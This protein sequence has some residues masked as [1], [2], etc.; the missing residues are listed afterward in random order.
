MIGDS[1]QFNDEENIVSYLANEENSPFQD[2][3]LKYNTIGTLLDH[4][5]TKTALVGEDGNYINSKNTA[6]RLLSKTAQTALFNYSYLDL[7]A[8]QGTHTIKPFV[9]ADIFADDHYVVDIA[10]HVKSPESSELLA[11]ENYSDFSI[12]FEYDVVV[13]D[14]YAKFSPF[15]N[16]FERYD[17][18]ADDIPYFALVGSRTAKVSMPADVQAEHNNNYLSDTLKYDAAHPES[19]V[20]ALGVTFSNI[21]KNARGTDGRP[22]DASKLT[23]DDINHFYFLTVPAEEQENVVSFTS[24]YGTNGEIDTVKNK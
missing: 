6:Y 15:K 1:L 13:T 17:T 24:Q 12:T 14:T 7:D 23:E 10:V 2:G 21:K 5:Q 9:S 4:T 11:V 22:T 16:Q 19:V 18:G 20:K 8:A 3:F